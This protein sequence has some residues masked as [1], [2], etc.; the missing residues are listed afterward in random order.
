MA[1]QA[2]LWCA[3]C[4][5]VVI[6]KPAAPAGFFVLGL[7]YAR[8]LEFVHECLHA[9]ALPRPRAN[10]IAGTLLAI[11][12]LVSFRQWRREHMRH[13]RDV[14]IE[15]FNYKYERLT[16]L[17]EYVAHSLMLRHF[18]ESIARI[19]RGDREYRGVLIALVAV[20][21]ACLA[22]HSFVP[23]LLWIAPLPFAAIIHAHIEL[24]EHFG[25]PQIASSDPL[26]NSRVIPAGRFVTWLVNA[27]NYHAIHHWQPRLPIRELASSYAALPAASVI[28]TTYARFYRDF[29]FG[30]MRGSHERLRMRA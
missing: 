10:A 19:T 6:T 11:P 5:L 18:T 26:R 29:F 25:L 15:G 24:P 21:L 7:V 2:V 3:G 23:A 27:N 22:L 9:T 13:H 12:M 20:A 1:E 4:A 8:N 28:T 17:F 14:R 30:L 16:N